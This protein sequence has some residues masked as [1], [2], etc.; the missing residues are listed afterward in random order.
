M[1]HLTSVRTQLRD[2]HS[3][4]AALRE[5]GFTVGGAGVVHGGGRTREVAALIDVPGAHKL[6]L[7]LTADGTYEVAGDWYYARAHVGDAAAFTSRLN[8]LY[9][10]HRATAEAA[11]LGYMVERE[12]DANGV[13]RLTLSMP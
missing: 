2:L 8:Q 7:A 3:A 11:L 9:G 4:C 12:T 1:S 5:M 6:G 13:I 10:V